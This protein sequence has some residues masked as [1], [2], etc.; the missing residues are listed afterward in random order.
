[1]HDE[2]G[3]LG[4]RVQNPAGDKW[5]IYGD[6]KLFEPSN[7]DN[8]RLCSKAIQVSVQE[9]YDAYKT[10]K[11]IGEPQFGAWKLA[12]ILE[13]VSSDPENHLPLLFVKADGKIYKRNGEPGQGVLVESFMDYVGL[14]LENWKRLEKQVQL[15]IKKLFSNNF[16]SFVESLPKGQIAH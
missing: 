9:V 12:P 14:L 7:S 2:D 6:T 5:R 1:M 8:L 11:S 15:Q 13:Q 10:G 4:L 16:G 3:D